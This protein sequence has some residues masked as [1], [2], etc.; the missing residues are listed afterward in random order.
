MKE[1]AL[2]GGISIIRY[3]RGIYRSWMNIIKDR[4]FDL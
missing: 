3:K 4:N 1:G 2:D